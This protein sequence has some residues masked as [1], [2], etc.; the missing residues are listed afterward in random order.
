MCCLQNATLFVPNVAVRFDYSQV[1]AAGATQFISLFY[2]DRPATT[3]PTITKDLQQT[4]GVSSQ[5]SPQTLPACMNL[6]IPP[7]YYNLHPIADAGNHCSISHP[8]N[9]HA[10]PQ[11]VCSASCLQDCSSVL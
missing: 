6:D 7:V 1:T 10:C 4:F 11:A 5:A 3:N 8:S 2:S 9:I